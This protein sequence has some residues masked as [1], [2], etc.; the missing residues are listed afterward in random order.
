[1]ENEKKY[2][3]NKTY[4]KWFRIVLILYVTMTVF[5]FIILPIIVNLILY[6]ILAISTIT[7]I[8]KGYLDR[9]S[10]SEQGISIHRFWKKEFYDWD[11]VYKL[12]KTHPKTLYHFNRQCY[13]MY[14]RNENESKVKEVYFYENK[15]IVNGIKSYKGES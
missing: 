12:V 7:Y 1:M 6:S 15:G 2:W 13:T 3:L 4:A 8:K 10:F 9:I 14:I 11:S 5:Y